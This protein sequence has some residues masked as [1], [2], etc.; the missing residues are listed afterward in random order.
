M[1]PGRCYIAP[2]VR[3]AIL[4][5]GVAVAVWASSV[6]GWL[7]AIRCT[8]GDNVSPTAANSRFGSTVRMFGLRFSASAARG[9]P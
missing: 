8:P 7:A 2:A 9:D 3:I 6:V 1:G 4:L 5:Y